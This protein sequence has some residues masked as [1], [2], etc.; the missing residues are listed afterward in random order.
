MYLDSVVFFPDLNNELPDV[1]QEE[2]ER[3][4][5]NFLKLEKL[6]LIG[7]ADEDVVDPWQST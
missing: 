1:S 3:K 5:K 6:A 2:K 7:G 4:K